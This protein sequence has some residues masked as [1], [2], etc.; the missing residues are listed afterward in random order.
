MDRTF[1]ARAYIVRYTVI[2]LSFVAHDCT[3]F[4]TIEASI[5]AI[6]WDT[7]VEYDTI[8]VRIYNDCIFIHLPKHSKLGSCLDI[9]FVFAIDNGIDPR[10]YCWL[11]TRSRGV[12]GIIYNY[13]NLLCICTY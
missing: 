9:V 12:T 4:S 1:F 5:P 2:H 10:G 11:C 3:T 13:L 7:L 6:A 8:F